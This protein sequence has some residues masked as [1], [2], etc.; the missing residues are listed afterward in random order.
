MI[1]EDPFVC[2]HSSCAAEISHRLFACRR[3]WFELS[4]ELRSKIR[5]DWR[6]HDIEAM[7]AN[8]DLAEAEWA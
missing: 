4:D 3:H 1:P 8:Y 2:P 5:S 7:I 6:Q